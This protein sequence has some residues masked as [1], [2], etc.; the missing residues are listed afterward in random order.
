MLPVMTHGMWKRD[1]HLYRLFCGRV[2][3]Q[4]EHDAR[5]VRET[6][7]GDARLA[8]GHRQ[9]ANQRDDECLHQ[10]PVGV[11]GCRVGA[12]LEDDAARR[13]QHER[14]VGPRVAASCNDSI[15]I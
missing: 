1:I 3:V 6:H 10:V 5:L 15:S 14:Y 7:E 11:V 2:A 13:V 12:R 8:G 4:V 9:A